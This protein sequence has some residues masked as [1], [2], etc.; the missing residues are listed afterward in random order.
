MLEL[1]LVLHATSPFTTP[2]SPGGFSN[3]AP[4]MTPAQFREIVNETFS[5]NISHIVSQTVSQM[6]G[7]LGFLGD[8]APPVQ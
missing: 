2:T 6:L 4:T 8:R 7:Q 1:C 3:A 5:Q